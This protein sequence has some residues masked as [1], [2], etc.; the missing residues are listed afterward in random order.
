MNTIYDPDPEI[1][2]FLSSV[3]SRAAE[4]VGIRD[5]EWLSP[6]EQLEML[7][8]VSPEAARLFNEF[9]DSYLAW[10]QRCAEI[11]AEGKDGKLSDTEKAEFLQLIASRDQTRL[12]LRQE[13]KLI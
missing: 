5:P 4:Q 12:N 6:H 9:K 2:F 3:L 1:Q 10:C 13:L 8:V 11:T 7:R